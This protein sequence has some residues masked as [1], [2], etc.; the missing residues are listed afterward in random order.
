MES[1]DE[2]KL[3]KIHWYYEMHIQW[4]RYIEHWNLKIKKKKKKS[5]QLQF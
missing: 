3:K 5:H 1:L 4:N 2:Y